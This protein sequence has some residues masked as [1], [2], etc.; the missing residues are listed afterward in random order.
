[1]RLQEKEGHL[2]QLGQE[3][4]QRV[5]QVLRDSEGELQ[6]ARQ[7]IDHGRAQEQ[8][9]VQELQKTRAELVGL[10]SG[11]KEREVLHYMQSLE[12]AR[13][14]EPQDQAMPAPP[15]QA[16]HSAFRPVPQSV[17]APDPFQAPFLNLI[18]QRN[19]QHQSQP[20]GRGQSQQR[21]PVYHLGF[22]GPGP[23]PPWRQ[24]VQHDG[25]THD[26]RS[27]PSI[28]EHRIPLPRQMTFDG[29][30]TWQSFILP[31][32]SLAVACGW[33]EE[34][35][36]FRLSNSLREEAAEYAF[37]QLTPEVVN[38]FELLE[39]A[40]DARFAE[41]R[42][43]A[44]YLAALEARKLQP[45]EKLSE[46]VADI[47]KLVIKG[48]PTADQQTRDT[49]GLRYFL[50]GLPDAQMAIAVGMKDP[51][52]LDEARTILDTYNSLHDE[53]VKPPRVRAIQST[54]PGDKAAE[55]VTEARLQEFGKDLKSGL[56]SQFTELKDLIRQG[57][58]ATRDDQEPAKKRAW[59]P[60][61]QDRRSPT[62]EGRKKVSFQVECYACHERGHYARECPT[63][64]D[65]KGND[66]ASD[67]TQSDSG[68][69]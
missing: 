9:M 64:S 28:G 57:R 25:A 59:S 52:T 61:P 6:K 68:N 65:V 35:K 29:R 63:K 4:D 21:H 50:K 31:F 45:K 38:S 11:Q 67:N 56:N 58:S 49:I 14:Q 20:S 24:Q 48:Y 66:T 55:Y 23:S 26:T 60:R 15:D 44:S 36:L 33:S 17:A 18:D 19:Q 1:M 8:G 69:C 12:Q 34:E 10:Q 16:G 43:T 41:K 53:T 2:M 62:P 7:I 42:T 54:T 5:A 27:S 40:L 47:K 13:R 37:E 32:K 22:Q 3:S 30:T 39:L 51:G 46:Y